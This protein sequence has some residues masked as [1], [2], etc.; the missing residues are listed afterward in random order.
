MK[1]KDRKN[2]KIGINQL[3]DKYLN[4]TDEF[5]VKDKLEFHRLM[6]QYFNEK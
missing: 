3:L 1:N 5:T 6:M 2:L 4:N